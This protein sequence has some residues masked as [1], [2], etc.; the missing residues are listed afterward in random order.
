MQMQCDIEAAARQHDFVIVALHKGLVH[1][2]ARLAPYERPVAHAAIDAGA[3]VVISH[4]AHLI[5]GMEFHRGRPIFHGLGNGCV[6]T[7]ALSPGQ[8]DP[9]RESWV[10]RRKQLFGFEPD[11]A[12]WLAPF[13]P[14]AVNAMLG[15]LKWH[16]DGRIEAG[17]VPLHVDAPGLP[18]VAEA[19]DAQAP[20]DYMANITRDAGLNS[21]SFSPRADM[22]V[23]A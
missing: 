18:V 10:Q 15:R 4:H 11:P 22:V 19:A 6:V 16:D 2:P 21:L 5:R 1:V 14:D 20:T 9:A 8:K 7:R 13:H 23:A 17:Y 12:Y 3:Q